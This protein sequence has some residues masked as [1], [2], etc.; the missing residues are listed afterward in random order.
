VHR[1]LIL[2]SAVVFF[3]TLFFAVLTPL[4]PHY[5]HVLHMGKTGAGVLSAAYPA[6][7]LVGAVPSGIVAGRVGLKR[8][9]IVGL[10]L[11]GVC[12]VAFGIGDR[13]WELDLARF[14]QGIASAFSWTGAM[15]WLVSEAPPERRGSLIGQA[16]AA[17]VGGSL[18]GP[19]VGGVASVAGIGVTFAAVAALSLGLV[20]WTATMQAHRPA[21]AQSPRALVTAL[22]DRGVLGGFWL[23][24]LPSL[25]FGVLDVLAPLRL[26]ALGLGAV[27]IGAVFFSS[28]LVDIGSNLVVGRAADRH[29]TFLPLAVGVGA[30][31][32]FAALL[33]WPSNRVVLVPLLVAAGVAFGMLF[34]PAMAMLTEQGE[35]CGLEYGFSAALIN[36]AWA[37]GQ[38]LG[39]AGGGAL[40]H[41]AGDAL[42]YLCLVMVC[43]LTLAVLWRSRGSTA[44]TTRSARGSSTSSSHII[45]AA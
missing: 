20:A 25:L 19:V 14:V 4:L 44:W 37:P 39:S 26:A 29:G 24:A 30:S 42:T 8:S 21:Q 7:A 38:A 13:G 16:F 17:A 28:A 9:V 23:V 12:T 33:P 31:A 1:L 40:A 36:L 35:R 43:A 22:R 3:D 32:I 10:S 6:G 2:T 27:A 34:T 15:G 18:F 5:V 11:V 45:D 41:R